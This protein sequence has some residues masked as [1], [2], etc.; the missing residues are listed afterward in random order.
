MNIYFIRHGES[1]GNKAGMSQTPDMPLSEEGKKQA[2]A[3]AG[4]LKNLKVDFIYSSHLKRARQTSE[5]ISKKIKKPIEYWE[6]LQEMRIPRKIQ[7]LTHDDK[8]DKEIRE[9]IKKNYYKGNWKYSNEETFEELKERCQEILNHLFEK[10]RNQN[11][12]CVSH[13][14]VI[15][16]VTALTIFG[17]KLTPSLFWEFWHHTWQAN[18]GIT[19]IEYSD[20]YGWALLAWNDTTHL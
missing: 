8:K 12:L 15:K 16:M 4:R 19:Q 9:L 14:G 11:I 6:G 5:I 3:L 2:Q 13:G 7:G 17:D 10:H 18:T 20:K 1:M